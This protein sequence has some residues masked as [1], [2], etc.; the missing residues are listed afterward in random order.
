MS[1]NTLTA[2]EVALRDVKNNCPAGWEP[3]EIVTNLNEEFE[4]AIRKVLTNPSLK[5][6]CSYYSFIQVCKK[7]NLYSCK[8]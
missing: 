4:A 7:K 3:N 8:I 1:D 2:Y 5:V 6:V